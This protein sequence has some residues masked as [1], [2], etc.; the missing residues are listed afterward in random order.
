MQLG[1][2]PECLISCIIEA[3]TS[4]ISERGVR[5]WDIMRL[6][7]KTHKVLVLLQ[8]VVNDRAKRYPSVNRR[9]AAAQRMT[10]NCDVRKV[11]AGFRPGLVDHAEVPI[12]KH[13]RIARVAKNP[14]S[15]CVIV[16][17]RV[18][19]GGHLGRDTQ[20][21]GD[22]FNVVLRDR[23]HRVSAAVRASRAVNV[24]LH[25]ARYDLERRIR[26][27]PGREIAPKRDVLLLFR[28]SE[29]TDLIQIGNHA[30]KSI[31]TPGGMQSRCGGSSGA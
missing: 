13:T 3:D 28:G 16:G 6:R 15:G 18:E 8:C 10:S 19:A 21:R 29:P 9:T 2:S 31:P 27:V 12:Q 26:A 25:F 20:V 22:P 4:P 14:K 23:D 7:V 24:L 11:P 30:P 1:F 17:N 5:L